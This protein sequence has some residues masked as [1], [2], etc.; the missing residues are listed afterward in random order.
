MMTNYGS[1]SNG[2]LKL[3]TTE[4]EMETLSLSLLHRVNTY[5]VDELHIRKIFGAERK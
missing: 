5:S 1:R 2:G 3:S 4:I